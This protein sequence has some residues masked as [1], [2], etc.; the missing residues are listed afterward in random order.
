MRLELCLLILTFQLVPTKA[1]LSKDELQFFNYAYKDLAPS[2]S[3]NYTYSSIVLLET[4]QPDCPSQNGTMNDVTYNP[5]NM[6]NCVTN[7]GNE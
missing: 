2:A 7:V 6:S 3:W 5:Y 1:E 4:T